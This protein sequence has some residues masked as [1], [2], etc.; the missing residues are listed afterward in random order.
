MPSAF[1]I[2]LSRRFFADLQ[3]LSHLLAYFLFLE[4][5]FERHPRNVEIEV[6]ALQAWVDGDESLY[7]GYERIDFL[8]LRV[9]FAGR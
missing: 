9:G 3:K 7:L 8:E 1:P 4:R 5:R 2:E 6:I